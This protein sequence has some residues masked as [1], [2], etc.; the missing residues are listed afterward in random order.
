MRIPGP[1]GFRFESV[2]ATNNSP[3]TYVSILHRRGGRP[4][5]SYLNFTAQRGECDQCTSTVTQPNVTLRILRHSLLVGLPSSFGC[6]LTIASS[7]TRE[8]IN[9]GFGV[10]VNIDPLPISS[11][12]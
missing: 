7:S 10:G 12:A 8:R 11:S 6:G 3:G 5:R 9:L 1:M 4:Y 2:V